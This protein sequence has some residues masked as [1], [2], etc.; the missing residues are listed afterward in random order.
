MND[1]N[2][3]LLKGYN[4]LLYFAGSMLMNEPTE[5]CVIDFW[6]NGALRKLPVT[7]SNPRFIKAAGLL[8][9]SCSDETACRKMLIEDYTRLFAEDMLPL[10]PAY[11]SIYNDNKEAIR[12]EVTRF[13]TDYGWRSR[14]NRKVADDHLGLELLFLTK[15]VDK[16]LTMD[17]DPS[18]REMK[19]EIRRFIDQ[20]IM[21]WVPEWYKK[22]EEH[23][24][25]LCYKGIGLLVWACVE[26]LRGI[27][28]NRII[29]L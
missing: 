17:D 25:S 3:N 28:T 12:G 16:Y 1:D 26:D 4:H 19:K 5:E 10:A 9:Q 18:C 21:S 22:V 24:H 7:S 2:K 11:E 8:R 15:M 27:F 6:K 13:Y 29:Q 23:A 20:H 14:P